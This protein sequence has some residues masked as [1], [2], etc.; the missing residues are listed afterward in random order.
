MAVQTC[1]VVLTELGR[2]CQVARPADT[3]E[4]VSVMDPGCGCSPDPD[5][6]RHVQAADRRWYVELGF[7]RLIV[8]IA[9]DERAVG[10]VCPGFIAARIEWNRPGFYDGAHSVDARRW[11]IEHVGREAGPGVRFYHGPGDISG[12][13][14]NADHWL[15]HESTSSSSGPQFF[16]SLG[17]LDQFRLR[18]REAEFLAQAISDDI[19]TDELADAAS[20]LAW[21]DG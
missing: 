20:A 15:V 1:P 6:I 5:R 11:M 10:W 4:P 13:C 18:H 12:H 7:N 19:T 21:F 16:D 17:I 14:V 2:R 3:S 8:A 9:T